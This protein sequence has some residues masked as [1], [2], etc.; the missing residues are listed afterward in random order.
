M[1][2]GG[3]GL[4]TSCLLHIHNPTNHLTI[5]LVNT[6]VAVS[7]LPPSSTDKQHPQLH[8]NLL[9]DLNKRTLVDN[10]TQLTF[11]GPSLS[12]THLIPM[13]HPLSL[14]AENPQPHNY[15]EHPAKHNVVHT[16]VTTGQPVADAWLQN[17]NFVLS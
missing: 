13:P 16:I 17:I 11:A 9:V 8:F 5:D 7:V 12:T 4:S 6:C 1:T 10:T 3:P 14:M 2:A 15:H